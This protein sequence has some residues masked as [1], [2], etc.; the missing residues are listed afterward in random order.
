MQAA[1]VAARPD[2]ARAVLKD[3]AAAGVAPN[4]QVYGCMVGAMGVTGGDGALR[5][6]REMARAGVPPGPLT[7]RYA[8]GHLAGEG[9]WQGGWGGGGVRGAWEGR[10]GW[11]RARRGT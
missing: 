8:M 4:E 7:F 11:K 9:E 6:L 10:G 1:A 2:A 5:M 3:M